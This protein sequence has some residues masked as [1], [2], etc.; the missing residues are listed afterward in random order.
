MYLCR[1]MVGDMIL[2]EWSQITKNI[3]MEIGFEISI[4]TK[5]FIV[6]QRCK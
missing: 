1:K 5:D 3:M 4:M 2:T 6:Y